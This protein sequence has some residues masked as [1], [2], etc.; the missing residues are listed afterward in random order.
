M[1]ILSKALS[2]VNE[3]AASAMVPYSRISRTFDEKWRLRF[4]FQNPQLLQ[5]VNCFLVHGE[6]GE[7]KTGRAPRGRLVR[8][9]QK[10]LK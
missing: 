7:L 2:E 5:Y 8:A 1:S 10:W 6:K 4:G 3:A 9:C